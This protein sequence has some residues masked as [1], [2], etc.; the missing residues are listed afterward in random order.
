MRRW[1]KRFFIAV[2]TVYLTVAAV[3]FFAQRRLIYLP[4]VAATPAPSGLFRSNV[5]RTI[6]TSDGETLAAWWI[7]PVD[8]RRIF[9]YLHG[10]GGNLVTYAR[11]FALMTGG[12]EGLL[13]IDWRGYGAST[14]TPTEEGLTRDAAAA[15]EEALK[16]AGDP[17]KIVIVGESLG[18][19][20]AVPLAARV[21]AA[22]LILDSSFSSLVDVGAARYGIFPVRWL[23]REQY[24]SDL[25]I[26]AVKM[27][28]LILHGDAD[29]IVPFGLGE[30]LFGRAS[31]PKAFVRVPGA[32]HLVL[33]RPEVWPQV[34]AWVDALP[35]T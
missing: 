11:R 23:M 21:A 31:E 6:R 29:R 30:A 4:T 8:G 19:G 3:L 2:A 14:G 10:N 13:A 28:K 25:S 16:L 22:G 9:L 7:P 15:Y 20:L 18:T 24:R 27:P 12:G 34:R 33:A 26:G 17:R 5:E 1:L 35:K 32:D